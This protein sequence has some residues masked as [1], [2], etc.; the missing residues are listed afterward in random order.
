MRL[1]RLT[2]RRL[3]VLVAVA[4]IACALTERRAKSQ[5]IALAHEAA[6]QVLLDY[7]GFYSFTPIIWHE[8]MRQ[9]YFDAARR[10]WAAIAPDPPEPSDEVPALPSDPGPSPFPALSR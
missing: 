5:R 7:E 9:K 3:I 6:L 8:E 4:G 10:P 1:P 2:T